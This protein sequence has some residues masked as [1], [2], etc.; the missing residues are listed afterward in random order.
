[1]PVGMERSLLLLLLLLLLLV[2]LLVVVLPMLLLHAGRRGE[3][4]GLPYLLHLSSLM[5]LMRVA[6][7]L[8][9]LL[10]VLAEL[11][12][13]V[14]LLLLLAVLRRVHRRRGAERG[15]LA[16]VLPALV[17]AVREVAGTPLVLAPLVLAHADRPP[18][19][20]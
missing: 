19:R 10:W 7:L 20:M 3:T 8:L 5:P 15:Q 9:A 14:L 11:L 13:P 18:A 16:L 17:A 2:L 1:L 6:L 4:L 12:L